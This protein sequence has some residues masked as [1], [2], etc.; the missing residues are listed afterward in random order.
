MPENLRILYRTPKVNRPSPLYTGSVEIV[1][2]GRSFPGTGKLRLT[3]LPCPMVRFTW[4]GVPT[5]EDATRLDRRIL[6]MSDIE[7][8]NAAALPRLGAVRLQ[9]SDTNQTF[10][11]TATEWCTSFLDKNPLSVSG[12]VTNLEIPQS[13]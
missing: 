5:A 3:W 4:H 13:T 6:N 12:Y 10:T 8:F 1:Q 7:E 11:G 2:A 9:L